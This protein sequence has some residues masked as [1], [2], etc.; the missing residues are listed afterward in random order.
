MITKYVVNGD[1]IDL[2]QD[3]EIVLTVPNTEDN[4]ELPRLFNNLVFATKDIEKA[5]RRDDY[6]RGKVKRSA[7]LA[8]CFAALTC[9]NLGTLNGVALFM[10]MYNLFNLLINNRQE[11]ESYKRLT[12]YQKKQDEIKSKLQEIKEKTDGEK[13]SNYS[14][15]FS[16][17]QMTIDHAEWVKEI[18]DY[19]DYQE[20]LTTIR[21]D[22]VII[23]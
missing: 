8:F 9:I 16:D 5:T 10:V 18:G 11:K 7:L 19:Y 17:D 1:K 15:E 6:F 2:Y 20:D 23:L 4:T 14:L 3:K 12:Q 13:S 21:N 22:K